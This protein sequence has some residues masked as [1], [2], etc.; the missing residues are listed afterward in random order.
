MSPIKIVSFDLDGTLVD[1]TFVNSIWFKGLPKLYA[2]KNNV[3]LRKAMKYLKSEYDKVGIE[4]LEWYDIKYWFKKYLGH[5]DWESLFKRMRSKVRLYSEVPT[6]LRELKD[7]GYKLIIVSNA[8]REFL[9]LELEETKIAPYFYRVFSSTSDFKIVKKAV[10]LYAK[11][12]GTLE[13]SPCEVANVGDNWKFDFQV[14][15]RLGIKAFYLDRSRHH[16]GEYTLYSLKG[17]VERLRTG[18]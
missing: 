4:S 5:Q 14:P 15:R 1:Y 16:A 7:L 11:I 8:A 18:C 6:V 10:N 17:L 12:C 2:E 9:D 3:T 13:V